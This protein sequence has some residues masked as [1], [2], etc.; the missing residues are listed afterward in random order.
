ME[1]LKKDKQDQLIRLQLRNQTRNR[2]KRMRKNQDQR[3]N[4]LYLI[5]YNLIDYI[6]E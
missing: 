2:R 3:E 4:D 5:K 1:N 6:Y